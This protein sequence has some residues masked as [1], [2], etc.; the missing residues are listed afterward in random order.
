[1]TELT[2]NNENLP[3][4]VQKIQPLVNRPQVADDL[5]EAAVEEVGD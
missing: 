2:K 1:M 3:Q 5:Q 4:L